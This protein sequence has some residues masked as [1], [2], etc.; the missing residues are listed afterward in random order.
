MLRN[1]CVIVAGAAGLLGAKVATEILQAGGHVVAVD[2]S[3]DRMSQSLG[4]ANVDAS[5]D[6][7][8]LVELDLTCEVS[9]KSFFDEQSHI[10]GAVN[11][12]YPRNKTYGA[13]FFDVSLA[14]FN[15]NLGLHL[16][17]AFLFSQQCAVYFTK[18]RKSFSLVNVS[19][20]YGVIAPKFDIYCE[21]EMTMPVEYAAIKSAIIHLNKY[22][23]SYVND[24]EF[25]ANC[26]SPGGIFDHQPSNFLKKYKEYTLG[27]GMLDI[28]DVMGAILFLLSDQSKFINGQ[29]IVIDDGFTL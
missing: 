13:H 29:N 10:D 19:S 27:K 11:C 8:T 21:T 18:A 12:S 3:L 14:S 5:N 23:A 28:D 4:K 6:S 2:L 24:S 7:L 15:E 16:G 9:V 25:R 22:I 26:I 17:S 20:V 1:K